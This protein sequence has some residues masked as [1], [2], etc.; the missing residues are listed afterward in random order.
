MIPV[1][2]IVITLTFYYFIL[3]LFGL[4]RKK[5]QKILMPE[6]SFALVVAA[7]NEEKVI[8]PLVENLL[9]M[10]YPRELF[11]V[12]VIADNCTDQTALIAKK[13]GANV[14]QRF[15]NV[16]RGKGYALEW[17]FNRLFKLDRGYDAVIIFDADNL[18]KENFL[19]EM[20]SKLCQGAK[21]VQG[22]LDSK[23]PYDTWVT[24]AFSITFWLSNRLLQLSRF[25]LGLSNVLGGTGMC[26]S[27]DVLKEYGW[28]ATSLTED[29]EFSVK[30]LM[31]GVKTTWAHDAVVYDEK[32]LTFKQAW[33]QRKRWA[34]GQVDVAGRYLIPLIM[35][36]I[37]ERKFMYIDNAIHLFQ[38]ALVM[39]ATFFTLTNIIPMM[40][41]SYPPLFSSV[42][43][44]TGWQI[45]SAIQ[46]F[47]PVA[48]LTLERIPW[49]A[50]VGLIYYPIFIYSWIP[51]VFLGFLHRKDKKWS[52]TEH[53]R[54]IS[55]EEIAHHRKASSN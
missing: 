2:V 23:N 21:I 48:A 22:Y 1:Q 32:A 16:K 26:I 44:W 17:M 9:G 4:F 52:H 54:S 33:N 43:P 35:K 41:D 30:A 6:K 49:R 27:T 38:P 51:I 25:N 14:H 28:G 53:V 37:K 7:H 15:N 10:D 50:Y 19:I 12:Y 34:Q 29:L 8:G 42:M 36:G 13:S 3:S 46:F 40:Q 5:E 55:Y 39:I 18:V 45:L 31:H 24:R 20:N 11:D 47:Y